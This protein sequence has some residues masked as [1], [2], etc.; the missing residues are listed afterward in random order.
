[1]SNSN[2]IVETSNCKDTKDISDKSNTPTYDHVTL[3]N[4]LSH[5]NLTLARIS[6]EINKGAPGIDKMT[7]DT[8]RRYLEI[9]GDE[10]EKQIRTGKYKP[11]AIKRVYIPKENGQKRPL[12]I[13]TVIDRYVQQAVAQVL[14]EAFEPHFSESSYGYRPGRSARQAVKQL[15]Q[16]VNGGYTYVIDLDL[17]KFFDTVNHSK[18]LQILSSKIKDGRAISLIHKFLKAPVQENGQIGPN[19]TIGTPQGGC[20]SPILANILLNELDQL[21]DRRGVKFLRYADDMCIFAKSERAARRI[22]DNVTK[23]IEKKLFLKVNQDKTKICA[24]G[25]EVQFLG[26]SLKRVYKNFKKGIVPERCKWYP[27][28]SQKKLDKFKQKV[29]ELLDRKAPGGVLNTMN[30]YN[31]FIRGWHNYYR[32]ALGYHWLQKTCMLIRRRIRQLY[33]KQWKTAQNRFKNARERWR[34]APEIG[35]TSVR[36]IPY[37]SPRYWRM[38]RSYALNRILGNKQ[39]EAEGW[40]S[41]ETLDKM[42]WDQ[43]A[44]EKCNGTAVDARTARPVV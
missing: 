1:M 22:L 34:K 35:D 31:R 8:L 18:L 42:H 37:S 28:V 19:T 25:P 24:V 33:W 38:S 29:K 27:S 13:P 5:G 39:I 4:I 23:F 43:L 36:A 10:L 17:S 7:T 30:R 41:L 15:T 26:F 14:S 44:S 16:Y 9:Y 11:L 2:L 40:L 6:V 32:G 3:E 20:I 12:G 21:L